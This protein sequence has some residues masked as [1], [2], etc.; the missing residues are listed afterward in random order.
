MEFTHETIRRAFAQ[1][2]L[3]YHR[4]N[5][6]PVGDHVRC[7]EHARAAFEEDSPAALES[8]FTHLRG[9]WQVFRSATMPV[10]STEKIR[11]HLRGL[12]VEWRTKRLSQLRDE[13]LRGLAGIVNGM[14]GMKPIKYPPSI[15]AISK[16]LHFFNPRLF[17]IVDDAIIWRY[18]LKHR[19]LWRPIK[20]ERDRIAPIVGLDMPV[21]TACDVLSF[22]AIMR[23]ASKLI[24]A[25]PDI[26]TEFAPYVRRNSSDRETGAR[27]LPL[28]E[29]EAG[30]VEWFLLGVVELPPPEV[31]A[32]S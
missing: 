19:W 20:Q 4:T 8:L 29:Y 32:A 28:E 14:T 5:Q 13:D 6:W 3:N 10:W 7:W 15:V 9:Y 1:H 16:V 31:A 2:E 22:I 30:A 17:P 11:T 23:W 27:D 18:V 25:N 26:M 24:A 21:G 12:P